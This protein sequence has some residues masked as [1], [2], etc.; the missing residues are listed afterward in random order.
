MRRD[1]ASLPGRDWVA[2]ADGRPVG[3][4]AYSQAL[5]TGADGVRRPVATF[6]PLGVLPDWQGGGLRPN[7]GHPPAGR[8]A[9]VRRAG[10]HRRSRL[11]PPLWLSHR[12][13][14]RHP[15]GRRAPSRGPAGKKLR[16]GG[17]SGVAG[18]YCEAEAFSLSP[19][20]AELRAFERGFPP[21][22]RVEGTPSQ[23]RFARSLPDD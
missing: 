20:D 14:L 16:P 17:L 15:P 11:L 4:I 6:G 10:H 9:G 21:K 3:G 22:E 1:P 18:R 13:G 7:R 8:R 19:D 2:L 5:V 12:Q 23:R